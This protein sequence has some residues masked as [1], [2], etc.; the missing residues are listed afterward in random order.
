MITATF[1]G[2]G[3]YSVDSVHQWDVNRELRISGLNLPSLPELHF[4]NRQ[5]G[6]AVARTARLENGAYVVMIPNSFLQYDDEIRADVGIYGGSD[7]TE[8]RI[9]ETVIIP[10]IGRARPYDYKISGEDD[11][12]YSFNRVKNDMETL[13]HEMQAKGSAIREGIKD[14]AF[15]VGTA[16][17]SSGAGSSAYARRGAYTVTAYDAS[18]YGIPISVYAKD[19]DG[20]PVPAT[21]RRG[22]DGQVTAEAATNTENVEIHIVFI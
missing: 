9:V 4:S 21:M 12:I 3:S 2:Y 13:R 16:Q 17:Y 11:E 5:M 10:V 8:F 14:K 22:E 7:G 6:G 1:S 15:K 19:S 18:T 20:F